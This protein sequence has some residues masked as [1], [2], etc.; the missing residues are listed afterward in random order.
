MS[1]VL[2]VSCSAVQRRQEP[3]NQQ[4]YPHTNIPVINDLPNSET[5]PMLPAPNTPLP[6]IGIILGPGGARTYAAIGVLRAFEKARI[7]VQSI[8][9]I[10]WGA[11]MASLYSLNGKANGVEWEAMKIPDG[12]VQTKF[13][14][15]KVEPLKFLEFKKYLTGFFGNRKIEQAQVSFSCAA[16]NIHNQRGLV[17][18]KGL[19]QET[20]GLCM[21][22]PPVLAA[23]Q[24]WVASPLGLS[25]MIEQM[26]QQGINYIILVDF[27]GTSNPL[28]G[29][30]VNEETKILWSQ[31]L[32][33][34]GQ[35][36]KYV[37]QVVDIPIQK[38]ILDFSSRRE[39]IQAGDQAGQKATEILSQKFG[40]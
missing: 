35:Y 38:S 2:F 15:S 39:F 26:S 29:A 40:F 10:E 11:L 6:K 37:H 16:E 32:R 4:T 36:R 31:M 9:G 22:Y 28:A 14:S 3:Q 27:L 18:T 24:G 25:R 30:R 5:Q 20:L 34:T 17:V 19:Y 21:D 23:N 1:T 12:I 33:I 13:L 8:G 7:P